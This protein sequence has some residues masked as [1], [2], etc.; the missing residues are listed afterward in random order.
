MEKDLLQI[1]ADALRKAALDENAKAYILQNPI[2]FG[3]LKKAADRYIGGETLEETIIKVKA[4][5]GIKC[6]IEFM[7]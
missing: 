4:Q 2:L 1:G 6:S 7:G 5:N 3:L